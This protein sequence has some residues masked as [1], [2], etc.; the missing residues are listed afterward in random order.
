MATPKRRPWYATATADEKREIEAKA[1]RRNMESALFRAAADPDTGGSL[2]DVLKTYGK[3]RNPLGPKARKPEGRAPDTIGGE[4][5]AFRE[6][7]RQQRREEEPGPVE[8]VMRDAQERGIDP[9]IGG[10]PGMA[11]IPASQL[12]VLDD[13]P[14]RGPRGGLVES[15]I[16]GVG[17]AAAQTAGQ[18]TSGEEFLNRLAPTFDP[19]DPFLPLG[20]QAG[21]QLERI[22][23]VGGAARTALD[24]GAAPLTAFTAGAG[25]GVAAGLRGPGVARG[26]GRALTEPIVRGGPGT[27]LAAEMALG[28]GFAEGTEALTEQGVPAPLALAG[29]LALGGAGVA[30]VRGVRGAAEEAVE[31]GIRRAEGPLEASTRG[32]LRPSRAMARPSDTPRRAYLAEVQEAGNAVRVPTVERNIAALESAATGEPISIVGFRQ[33]RGQQ[34]DGTGTFYAINPVHAGSFSQSINTPQRAMGP[35]GSMRV[36]SLKLRNPLVVDGGHEDVVRELFRMEMQRGPGAPGRMRRIAN[37]MDN[38]IRNAASGRETGYGILDRLIAARAKEFGFDG[39]VYRK[40]SS[41]GG[42]DLPLNTSEVV[43]FSQPPTRAAPS[44]GAVDPVIP[45]VTPR[46]RALVRGGADREVFADPEGL[47]PRIP[48][49][50]E[51]P[52]KL[53]HIRAGDPDPDPVRLLGQEPARPTPQ[54]GEDPV[55]ALRRFINQRATPEEKGRPVITLLRQYEAA[56]N[57]AQRRAGIV[58]DE[59]S[60]RLTDLGI[61]VRRAGVMIPREEDIPVLDDLFDALHTRNRDLAA[62]RGLGREYDELVDLTAWE[63]AARLDFDPE[64]ATVGDYFYR[65]WKPPGVS[66]TGRPRVGAT[67]SFQRPRVGATYREMR[68]AGFEPLSWNP[69]E[70]WRISRMQGIRYREQTALI[71]NLK[72]LEIARP[73]EGGPTPKGWRTPEIGPAFEGKPFAFEDSVTGEPRVGF[74]RRWVVP[75]DVANRLEN[76]YGKKPEFFGTVNIGDREIDFDKAIDWIAFVPKRAKLFGS[77]F[78]QQDFLT[79]SGVGAWSGAVDA[80]QA[81]Q[82]I[83]AVARVAKLPKTAVDILQANT[84]PATRAQIKRQLDD[85][86]PLVEGRPGISM[87]G[88]SEAGLSTIDV[89]IL[90]KDIDDLARIIRETSTA[91]KVPKRI[92]QSVRD[93]ETAMRRGLFEGVYPAAQMADIRNNI[94]PM[95][96][97]QHPDL[98]DEAIN[99][100]IAR[101]A[102]VRWSTVPAS[103]SVFQNPKM[104]AFLSRLF[105]S[106]GESEGMLRQA[107]GT[108][109]GSNKAFWGK[110]WI[111][112]YIFLMASANAV[113]FASTGHPLPSDRYVPISKDKWGP[114]PF[115]YNID[116]ASP[117]LPFVGRSGTRLMLDLVGQ[118][119]TGLRVLDPASFMS[120]RFSVPIRA[121]WNQL[122]GED[123]T[124]RPIDEVGPGGVVSRTQQLMFDLFSPIGLGQSGGEAARQMFSGVGRIIPEGESRIGVG[125]SLVQAAGLNVR[126]ERTPQL[127][128][129][130]AAEL[131]PQIN[132]AR[133][134]QGLPPRTEPVPFS[135]LDLFE[136]RIVD[137]DPELAQELGLRR[138]TAI[139]R[140]SE[141]AQRSAAVEEAMQRRIQQQT[142]DDQA[143][144]SGDISWTE[145]D[146]NSDV[147]NAFL[148]GQLEEI[149]RGVEDSRDPD[150]P[151]KMFSDVVDQFTNPNGTKDWDRIFGWV[152]SQ[153]DVRY[154]DSDI[155]GDTVAAYIERNTGLNRTPLQERR[156]EVANRLDQL[157]YFD[158]RDEA[159]TQLTGQIGSD[160]LKALV[161][162]YA[163]MDEF[164]T[165]L[166]KEE[167][168]R[169]MERAGLERGVALGRAARIID[170]HPIVERYN[171]ILRRSVLPLLQENPELATE[172]ISVGLISPSVA[173]IGAATGV[174][175]GRTQPS[176]PSGGASIRGPQLPSLPGLPR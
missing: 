35:L 70:Q 166:V 102:N 21:E 81:G 95:V 38:V 155:P 172:A 133:E 12:T 145:W 85:P 96:A 7:E 74:T 30:G 128:D 99:G 175:T 124:G 123:F 48:D 24:I 82:P 108:V 3:E 122:T 140:G 88:I 60:K 104:R 20:T 28:T 157:G 39:I 8:R 161:S 158:L 167:A 4:Y 23:I 37:A 152:E 53:S 47:R 116:F 164:T 76:I 90:P 57:T 173:N 112:A 120:S 80:L 162:P 2:P 67:P 13:F 138:E 36:D 106:V 129:R 71:D 6:R 101:L 160:D 50:I 137:A 148:S 58:V 98:P 113:H 93:L 73:H 130:K 9:L 25:P 150:D 139:E 5:L 84:S 143:V 63:E 154:E 111:G 135:E 33:V 119:D 22:P 56:V 165:A 15:A 10:A 44:P 68:E 62:A 125:G 19:S 127:L 141:G 79:R 83:S 66:T 87:R 117:D 115:G 170:S 126:G 14:D 43:V 86:T 40:P 134:E 51:D 142:V 65:G 147:R 61:G 156:S 49:P 55:D 153:E 31:Q 149:F 151:L 159:W 45:G 16:R 17:R 163:N 78:Q 59:G 75:N 42:S 32:A 109:S 26:V 41:F 29:G 118:L 110:H 27:R 176:R 171:L 131:L 1:W 136:R 103:Q 132:A 89:T 114:L 174:N 52:E 146:A 169:L 144:L 18:F 11:P 34:I 77:F 92:A 91:A 121:A 64:M 105:F 168:E 72:T 107:V 69:Y 97:R 100:M 54:R 94:A 46:G